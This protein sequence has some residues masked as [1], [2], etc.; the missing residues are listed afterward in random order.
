MCLSPCIMGLLAH[1][2]QCLEPNSTTTVPLN[3]F[4]IVSLC[5]VAMG[6]AINLLS[7]FL[8]LCFP[9]VYKTA[10]SGSECILL[11]TRVALFIAGWILV[12]KINATACDPTLYKWT[13]VFVVMQTCLSGLVIAVVGCCCCCFCCLGT[14]GATAAVLEESAV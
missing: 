1:N 13:L 5:V 3:T 8:V 6:L 2:P 14:L 9:D 11:L 4:L 10:T 12:T 7:G